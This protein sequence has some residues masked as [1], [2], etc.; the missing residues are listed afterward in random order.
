M[1]TLNCIMLESKNGKLVHLQKKDSNLS[2]CS[3]RIKPGERYLAPIND[4]SIRIMCQT[5]L[6]RI[7]QAETY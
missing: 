4:V 6:K 3:K 2:C 5:C 7:E 1:T